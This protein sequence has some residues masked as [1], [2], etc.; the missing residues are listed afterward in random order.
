MMGYLTG[1]DMTPMDREEWVVIVRNMSGYQCKKRCLDVFAFGLM[2]EKK[3]SLPESPLK[4]EGF[5]LLSELAK[6]LSKALSC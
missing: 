1:C 2:I 3:S 4:E 6:D 5:V